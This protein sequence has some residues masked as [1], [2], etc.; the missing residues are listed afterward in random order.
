MFVGDCK[1]QV[2]G[3]EDSI[4][5]FTGFAETHSVYSGLQVGLS[6]SFFDA[7]RLYEESQCSFQLALMQRPWWFEC[8][9]KLGNA[10]IRQAELC[11]L[12]PTQDRLRARAGFYI[13][14][15]I[16]KRWQ[17]LAFFTNRSINAFQMGWVV[18]LPSRDIAA[19]SRASGGE[20]TW[21]F[22]L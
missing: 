5:C 12:G 18:R 13:C 16:L 20:F 2:R 6:S 8:L 11:R 9:Q 14:E 19:I 3:S 15:S 17:K 22:V 1:V 21:C 4:S 7:Q 10:I